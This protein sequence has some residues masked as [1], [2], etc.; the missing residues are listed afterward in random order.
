[1]LFNKIGFYHKYGIKFS[2]LIELPRNKIFEIYNTNYRVFY[3]TLG[4]RCFTVWTT[5][6]KSF[7]YIKNVGFITEDPYIYNDYRDVISSLC[8]TKC[9]YPK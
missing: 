1:M 3:D 2:S 7:V 8:N 4:D 9:L 5:P 6:N